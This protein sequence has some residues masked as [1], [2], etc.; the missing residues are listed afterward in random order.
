MP[1]DMLSDGQNRQI[2]ALAAPASARASGLTP[3]EQER[4]ERALEDSAAG[5]AYVLGPDDLEDY[6]NMTAGAR[7][8]LHAS[9]DALDAWLATH[10]ATHH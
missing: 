9:R 7:A 8:E 5:R 6:A 10:A 1:H 4:I 3:V 2:G